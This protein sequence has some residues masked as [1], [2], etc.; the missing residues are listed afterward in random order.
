MIELI[1]DRLQFSFPKVHPQAR[2][3]ISFKRT[4]RIPDD[5]NSYPLPPGFK[6]FP[7]R[8]VDDFGARVPADWNEHGGVM[9]PMYQSE[10]MWVNFNAGEYP[11]AVKIAAGKINAVTG[12]DWENG[13][14]DDPQDYMQIPQQ[15]WLDGF[16]V[17]KGVVRQFVAMPLGEG[18]TAEEQLTGK[19]E[20]GGLQIIV[21]P[22]KREVY[23]EYESKRIAKEEARRREEEARRRD[24]EARRKM[25]A[26]KYR[27]LL[28][29]S[30]VLRGKT[31]A[32]SECR[33]RIQERL[34]EIER[35][36]ISEEY[37]PSEPYR[38]AM[39]ERGALMAEEARLSADA[40]RLVE[41]LRGME[42]E[43]DSMQLHTDAFVIDPDQ[44]EMLC[45]SCFME[46]S[47][48]MG[49]APGGKMSQEIY[50][51]EYGLDVWDVENSSR[52][53][54][55]LANSEMWQIIT[56]SLPLHRAP[57]F[58][59][60][61]KNGL[62]WFDYYSDGEAVEGSDTLKKLKSVKQTGDDKG[63]TPLPENIPARI[64]NVVHLGKTKRRK[65]QVREFT[66][67]KGDV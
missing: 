44:S 34:L 46:P 50:E 41:R 14:N 58:W 10:A 26:H 37:R 65:H 18:Y 7:L 54:V 35:H 55:H 62:P 21:Y 56:G 64:E 20:F 57:T 42:R 12:E 11:F 29:Q 4:L 52:C 30:A 15:P 6:N 31:I 25:E 16:C 45:C 43:V 61:Q 2:M 28:E 66:E 60:Y 23:E 3:G 53:F 32:L 19:A 5:G 67:L 40:G 13:L 36:L 47:S 33:K 39:R 1:K 38:D 17:E 48:A 9:M 63:E 59:D 49:M 22:M 27:S 51:D 8:H 24:E